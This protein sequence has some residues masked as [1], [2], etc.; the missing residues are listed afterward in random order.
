[1]RGRLAL[2]HLGA[3]S[4]RAGEQDD[5]REAFLGS[6][7]PHRDRRSDRMADDRKPVGIDSRTTAQ[8]TEGCEGIAC[9]VLE[10]GREVVALRLSDAALVE[11]ERRQAAFRQSRG[12][13]VRDVQRLPGHVRV[14]IER[15]GAV[16]DQRRRRRSAA[17]LGRGEGPAQPGA[18]GGRERERLVCGHVR[19]Q[20][21]HFSVQPT[22]GVSAMGGAS[23]ARAASIASRR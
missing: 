10:A 11:P 23:P 2:H 20:L 18:I 21:R 15:P 7:D 8:G 12:E 19:G 17:R 5:P 9:L 4:V 16:E 13:H 3:G 14:A 6:R 1:M 22:G